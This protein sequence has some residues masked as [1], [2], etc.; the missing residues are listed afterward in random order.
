MRR[1]LSVDAS[2]VRSAFG[3]NFLTGDALASQ[4]PTRLRGIG[5]K[6]A[7]LLVLG[8]SAAHNSQQG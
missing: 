6:T 3:L 2:L 5:L 7:L 1:M 4:I 8:A